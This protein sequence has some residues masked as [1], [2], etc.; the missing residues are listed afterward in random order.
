MRRSAL[1]RPVLTAACGALAA[2]AP[3]ADVVVRSATV[4]G[5]VD[6]PDGLTG[7]D[8]GGSAAVFGRS[9]W[10]YG[11][12]VLSTPDEAGGTWHTNSFDLRDPVAWRTDFDTPRDSVGAPRFLIE[13]TDDERAFDRDHAGDPCAVEPCNTRW[14]LWPSDPLWD[15]ARG[16]AWFLYG[17]YAD[18]EAS[19]I[20]VATWRGLDQPVVRQRMPNGSWLLFPGDVDLEW[21]NAPTVFDDHLFTFGCPQA[22]LSR[23]C[24]LARV[25]LASVA[26]RTAWR[27]WDGHDWS[28]DPDDRVVLFE[29]API[30]S[31]SFVAALDRW[32]LVYSD[33]FSI[34][35]EARTAPAL[36]GPWSRSVTLHRAVGE[37]AH[38]DVVHHADLQEQNGAVQWITWSRHTE[39]W[40][41]SEHVLLRVELDARHTP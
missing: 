13:L 4:E 10:T 32:L 16:Q 20:G 24:S 17:L 33:P 41:G 23:P 1:V 2:C 40:F 35:A 15:E 36:T 31:V 3:G 6:R 27:F 19:G 38:Y 34:E 9:V 12:T 22:G 14:A 21:S 28:A 11:D 29:G 37:D 18:G 39:G 7:R 30:M 8:G 5:V 25:P 26:D